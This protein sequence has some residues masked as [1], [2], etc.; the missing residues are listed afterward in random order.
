MVAAYVTDIKLL[1]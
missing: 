1:T